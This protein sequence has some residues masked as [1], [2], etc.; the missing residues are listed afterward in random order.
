MTT[1]WGLQEVTSIQT[2]RL[3]AQL[4]HLER[5]A[6]AVDYSRYPGTAAAAALDNRT[7]LFAEE[8]RAAMTQTQQQA[9]SQTAKLT[10]LLMGMEHRL[11]QMG[12]SMADL[13]AHQ[14]AHDKESLERKHRDSQLKLLTKVTDVMQNIHK[15]LGK[16]SDDAEVRSS[17]V[18]DRLDQIYQGGALPSVLTDC[19]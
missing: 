1:D 13:V 14:L 4:Q 18:L 9:N 10:K 11:E 15:K 7:Q 6:A 16:L 3:I 12:R 19:C 5:K 17:S 2:A 8:M